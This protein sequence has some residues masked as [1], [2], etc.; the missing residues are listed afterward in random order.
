MSRADLKDTLDYVRWYWR[1]WR[2]S[3]A[4]ASMSPLARG[5]YRELCDAHYGESDCALPADDA[6]IA[7][8]AG[9]PV[10]VWV[11]VRDEIGPW[12]KPTKSGK[13]RNPRAF[14]EWKA[15][16]DARRKKRDAGYLGAVA[17]YGGAKAMRQHRH[18]PSP[19]PSPAPSPSPDQK[20]RE[21][22]APAAEAAAVLPP[23][24]LI[25]NEAAGGVL[26]R[27]TKVAPA[28]ARRIE[29]RLR[30]EP[31]LDVWRRAFALI[32]ADPFC[33][34]QNDRGW[35]ADLDYAIRPEKSGRWLDLARSG[36]RPCEVP[37]DR[38]NRILGE[39]PHEV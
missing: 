16:R 28:R 36:S 31:D 38:M 14:H 12:L 3:T 18:G 11:A 6:G 17:R 2:S 24:V 19:S 20:Q 23:L 29:A 5:I 32:A 27:V 8:R 22:S 10:E 9:V 26:P 39:S 34:G 30:E 13:L 15:A 33:A 35:R 37:W 1:D 7:A 25:W 4:F 21:P